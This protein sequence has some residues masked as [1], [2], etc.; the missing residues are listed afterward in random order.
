[1]SEAAGTGGASPGTHARQSLDGALA[2]LAAEARDVAG[3]LSGM[4]SNDDDGPAATSVARFHGIASTASRKCPSPGR[5]EA[6]MASIAGML[7][8]AVEAV[9]ALDLGDRR[10]GV[11]AATAR[12][13]ATIASA[14]LAGAG[15]DRD[16]GAP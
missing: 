15:L 13:A 10:P 16:R 11:R 1:M 14:T 4:S 7:A 6:F 9:D 3:Q 12:M 2:D 8:S 5:I